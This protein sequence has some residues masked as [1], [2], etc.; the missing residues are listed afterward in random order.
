MI[1]LTLTPN[2]EELAALDAKVTE[3]NAALPNN[4]TPYTRESHLLEV[5]QGEITHL[6]EEKYDTALKRLG[7][8]FKEQPYATRLTVIANLEEQ[9]S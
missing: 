3:R 4:A 9:L 2:Q 5:V 8:A 1:S 6:A 7:G